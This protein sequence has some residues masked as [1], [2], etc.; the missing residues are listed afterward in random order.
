[1]FQFQLQVIDKVTKTSYIFDDIAHIPSK[2]DEFTL[3]DDETTDAIFGGVV[4]EVS[5]SVA[6]SGYTVTVT[7][8]PAI[9]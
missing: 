5:W 1:M 9:E 4:D 2:G 6:D 7:V 8:D 3:Y